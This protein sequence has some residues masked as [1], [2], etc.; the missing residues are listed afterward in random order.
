MTKLIFVDSAGN[1]SIIEAEDGVSVMR[2]ARDNSITAIVGRCGGTLACSTCHVYVADQSGFEPVSDFEDEM[3]DG[4][5][6]E[7]KSDSRLS[8]QLDVSPACEGVVIRTPEE[9]G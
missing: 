6:S 2:A 8:C 4:V 3:L 7:R 1:E 9:Q 5:W